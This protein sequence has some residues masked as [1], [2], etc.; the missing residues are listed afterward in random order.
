MYMDECVRLR[1]N[2]EEVIKSKDTFADPQELKIMIQR[3]YISFKLRT[4]PVLKTLNMDF[5]VRLVVFSGILWYTLQRTSHI[6]QE[7][8]MCEQPHANDGNRFSKTFG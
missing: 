4:F 3:T 6:E 8:V 5:F 7:K 2:L 1:S